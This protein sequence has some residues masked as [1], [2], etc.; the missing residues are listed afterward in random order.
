MLPNYVKYKYVE[1]YYDNVKD[2]S[3]KIVIMINNKS[4]CYLFLVGVIYYYKK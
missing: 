1:L 2:P 4:W 3:P